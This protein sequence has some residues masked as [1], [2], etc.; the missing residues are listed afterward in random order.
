MRGFV[1]RLIGAA[2]S[3]AA[4]EVYEPV[5]LRTALPLLGG[6]AGDLIFEQ[7]V[8]AAEAARELPV[9]DVPVGTAYFTT[10]LARRH[11]G[12]VVGADI[13]A[14]MARRAA[15]R[16]RE[17]GADDLVVVRADVH[18]LPFRDATFG[19][20]LCTN[21]LHVIPEPHRALQELHRVLVPGGALFVALLQLPLGAALPRR[22]AARLPLGLAGPDALVDALIG[23][24]LSLK[25]V[26]RERCA[27]LAEAIKPVGAPAGGLQGSR[28]TLT[29]QSSKNLRT[30]SHPS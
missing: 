26:R 5:V 15:G 1:K 19:A 11:A 17:A 23:A 16:G 13:A 8:V 7:G 3:V 28:R 14:G 30:K 18:H 25:A 12:V 24:G 10:E 20:A 29:S 6:A 9:L 2:Y 22:R 21:G 4:D 27:I